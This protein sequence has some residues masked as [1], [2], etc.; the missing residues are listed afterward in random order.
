MLLRY[1]GIRPSLPFLRLFVLRRSRPRRI[2][3]C[4]FP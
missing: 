3:V 2:A 1:G 4:L